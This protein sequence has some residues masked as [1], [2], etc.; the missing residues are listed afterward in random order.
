ML[1]K[2]PPI[3][4]LIFTKK[5]HLYVYSHLYFYKFLKKFPTY[6]FIRNRRLFGTLEYIKALY[7]KTVFCTQTRGRKLLKKFVKLLWVI[8]L[9]TY[10][11]RI[12]LSTYILLNQNRLLSQYIYTVHVWQI[13]T[14]D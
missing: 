13:I 5:F 1:P 12:K 11:I 14:L 3:R 6:I 10:S 4:L 7:Q 2:I 9:L 8:N